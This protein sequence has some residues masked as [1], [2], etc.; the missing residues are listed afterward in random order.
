VY[1]GV[2][3]AAYKVGN[4]ISFP[5]GKGNFEFHYAAL[6]FVAPEK[7]K[8]RYQLH[9]FDQNFI[10]A[11]T[12]RIAYYTKVPPG[13]YRFQVIACNNDGRWNESG[14]LF[15]FRVRPHFYQTY[16]FYGGLILF[17]LSGIYAF[18]R[19]RVRRLRTQFSAV[20]EERNRISREIHDTLTQNFTAVV[21]QLETAE[22]TL[23][24]EPDTTRDALQK[25][26][27]LARGGL[28]ES[29]RF[30]RALRPAPLEQSDLIPALFV[31]TAQAL[32]GS[33][34]EYKIHVSGKKRV[35]QHNVEDNLLRIT[36]E[37]MTNVVKHAQ[38]HHV[39]IEV[40]YRILGMELRIRDDGRGMDGLPSAKFEGGFGLIGIRERVAEMRGKVEINSKPDAGTEIIVRIPRW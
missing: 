23:E 7:V 25:A 6:S 35:L 12:R 9:G 10:D 16:W 13:D 34:V 19:L 5:P 11:S 3:N 20:L 17:A 40:I 22:L 31:V 38:A 39:E 15:S 30:V 4:N 37:A 26:R 2:D 29:R 8:F 28:A 21:L 36:Q 18:H 24:E 33:G 14:V 1:D 27:D 32:G